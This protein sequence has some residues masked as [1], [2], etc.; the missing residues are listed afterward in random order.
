[1]DL[2]EERRYEIGLKILLLKLTKGL[3]MKCVSRPLSSRVFLTFYPLQSSSPLALVLLLSSFSLSIKSGWSD[4]SVTIFPS[5]TPSSTLT[6]SFA[7]SRLDVLCS[8]E[9]ASPSELQR[10]TRN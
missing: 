3:E 2:Y 8:L 7:R 10:K 4:T 9:R 1:M 5:L 6:V